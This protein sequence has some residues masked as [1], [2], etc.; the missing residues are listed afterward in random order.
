MNYSK[1]L[2]ISDL[3]RNE[4]METLRLLGSIKDN[5]NM[6]TGECTGKTLVFVFD[7]ENRN[8][9]SSYAA[10]MA[11]LGGFALPFKLKDNENLK[12]S[13][14]TACSRGDIIAISHHLKGAA[15]A[16]SLYSTL[17]IINA[18]DLSFDLPCDTLRDVA[19]I[20][21]TQNHVSNMKIGFCGDVYSKGE[22]KALVKVLSIYNGNS[23]AF[24]DAKNAEISSELMSL[25]SESGKEYEHFHSLDEMIEDVDV[26]YM[27]PVSKEN[28]TDD[29]DYKTALDRCTLD[30]RLLLSAKATLSI[31]HPFPRSEELP[32]FVDFDDR[33]KY[34]EQLEYDV[35]SI[36]TFIYRMFRNRAGRIA[37]PDEVKSTHGFYCGHKECITSTEDY[38]PALFFESGDNLVCS[39]C[40]NNVET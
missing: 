26:L 12:D 15:L 11:R 29:K 17:P 25:I 28:F 37:K 30:A 21:Y 27:T 10:A 9:Q 35:L 2:D 32:V 4:L 22:V 33:A 1:I 36:M 40:K 6:F 34:F 23:F 5:T 16:A 18:G 7:N 39:Y 20:W 38:L 19:T 14:L 24:C 31:L 13:V 3:S 8:K